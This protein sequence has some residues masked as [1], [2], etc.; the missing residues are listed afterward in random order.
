MATATVCS[1]RFPCGDIVMATINE[2]NGIRRPKAEIIT[3]SPV[4]PGLDTGPYVKRSKPWDYSQ[5]VDCTHCVASTVPSTGANYG[6]S[7]EISTQSSGHV[8]SSPAPAELLQTTSACDGLLHSP[9]LGLSYPNSSDTFKGPYKTSHTVLS[10]ASTAICPQRT[11]WSKPLLP[12]LLAWVI[13]NV[14]SAA[15]MDGQEIPVRVTSEG[16]VRGYL[17]ELADGRGI[18]ERYL[19]IPYASPPV[20]TRRFRV[21]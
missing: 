18:S 20:G 10:T 14:V 11:E 16:P 13:L 6:P 2:A 1:P 4:A 9:T 15:G 17:H 8:S 21:N 5:T 12:L 3:A 7:P 19:G